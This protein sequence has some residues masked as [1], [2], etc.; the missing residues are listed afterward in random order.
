MNRALFGKVVKAAIVVGT[1][2]IVAAFIY[3][4]LSTGNKDVFTVLRYIASGV[5]G[6]EAHKGGSAMIIAGLIFHYIIALTFT[7]FFFWLYRRLT[8]LSKNMVLTGIVYGLFIWAVMNLLV[9][10]FSK[11]GSRPFNLRN[12]SINAIILIICIGIPLA[13]IAGRFYKERINVI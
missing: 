5:F 13:F 9:V 10:P 3:F 12:A 6:K 1:L 8:F 4:Y 2:D 11:I 7:L